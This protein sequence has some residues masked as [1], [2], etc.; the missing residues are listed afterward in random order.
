M[1]DSDS[2]RIFKHWFFFTTSFRSDFNMRLQIIMSN[3]INWSFRPREA[4]PIIMYIYFI[5]KNSLNTYSRC[6]VYL[7]TWIIVKNSLNTYSRCFVYLHTWMYAHILRMVWFKYALILSKSWRMYAYSIL[8]SSYTYILFSKNS[9]N[10]YSRC[11]LYH[12]TVNVCT[13]TPVVWFK[14]ALILS[15]SWCM[16]AY[17]IPKSMYKYSILKSMYRYSIPKSMCA[18]GIHGNFS[19][20]TSCSPVDTYFT[21]Y[22]PGSMA[23]FV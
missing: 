10:T 20:Y 13:Y 15:K 3:V 7:H 11:F 17:P 23:I 22:H 21:N 18:S 8:R 16:Y 1:M 4:A 19:H 2:I 14:Y 9:M 5:V 12:H 6:F